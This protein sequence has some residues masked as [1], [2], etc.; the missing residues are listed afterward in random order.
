M[1]SRRDVLESAC[2]FRTCLPDRVWPADTTCRAPVDSPRLLRELKQHLGR[3]LDTPQAWR[4][5]LNAANGSRR[6]QRS[7]RRVAG[8]QLV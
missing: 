4:P 2:R 5:S 6:Q 7:E 1:A 8:V 3:Y